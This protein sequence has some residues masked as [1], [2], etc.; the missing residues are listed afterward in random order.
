LAT[1][2]P[3]KYTGIIFCPTV[4][5]GAFVARRNGK[6]FLT[7]NSGFPKSLNIGKEVDKMQGNDRQV[8]ETKIK[9][10]GDMSS[11][12]FG[13]GGNYADIEVKITKGNSEWE[14]WGT[15]L[16]PSHEPICLAR[17]PIEKGLSIAENCLKWGTGGINIDE[18]RVELSDQDDSRLGGKGSWKTDKAAEN[19]YEGG[20]EGKDIASSPLG[21][22][23]ANFIHDKSEE[24]QRCF[25]DTK[26]GSDK[27]RN[28][29]TVGS[30]GMP[31][32]TTQEYS[33]SGNASR[34]FKSILYY[35]KASKSERNK[36]CE[37]LEGKYIAQGNQAQAEL[38]RGNTDFNE[39]NKH[40][41]VQLKQNFHPTVKPVAL[42][43]YLIKLV[44]PKGG[45]TLDPFGGSG[46]TAVAAIE[47]GFK[48][49]LIEKEA[50]HIPIIEA[51]VKAATKEENTAE[52]KQPINQLSLF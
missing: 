25:P 1:I 44:T 13:K 8:T 5:T 11:G 52:D 7:G 36:G 50:E 14:G 3:I 26:K 38:K 20:Y 9:K 10:A 30:F 27:P 49:I 28:R 33:D 42:I 47:N 48:Y 46:T 41:N 21:R 45:I 4:S 35:P 23:P 15:A 2:E 31:N 32:N 24:V 6:V 34:F 19:I 43:S 29:N 40:N 39:S 16:K 12:N 17:K 22:F 51:R 18:S 37:E